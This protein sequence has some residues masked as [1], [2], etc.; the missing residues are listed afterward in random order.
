MK[1]NFS[2]LCLLNFLAPALLL[3]QNPNVD[4][5][6]YEFHLKLNDENDVITGNT[7]IDFKYTEDSDVLE[8]DF[9]A[10]E[11]GKGMSIDS[12]LQNGKPLQFEHSQEKLTI[13]TS[14]EE[15][16]SIFYHGIPKDGLII[17]ENKYG[18]RTFFGD[19]WP[20]RAHLWL[21]IIDQIKQ[22]F[23]FT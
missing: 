2:L 17:S 10:Q 23:L 19:N 3:A 7:I 9:A 1:R 11:N 8:L 13:N 18:D 14:S 21:P 20:N 22:R 15:E 5:L 12:I 16:I 4:I 6:E